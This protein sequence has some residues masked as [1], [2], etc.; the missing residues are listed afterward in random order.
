MTQLIKLQPITYLFRVVLGS[1]FVSNFAT[2]NCG[3]WWITFDYGWVGRE[4]E[5]WINKWIEHEI[6]TY[7]V[8]CTVKCYIKATKVSFGVLK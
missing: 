5:K 1:Q 4:R 2:L 8:E 7:D 6:R 3:W